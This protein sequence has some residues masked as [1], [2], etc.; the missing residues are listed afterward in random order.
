MIVN[1]G[2]PVV[3]EEYLQHCDPTAPIQRF[4]GTVGE[5]MIV[6]LQLLVRCPMHR[7]YSSGPPLNDD[8]DI[9]NVA[10]DVVQRLAEVR[11]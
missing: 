2:A 5:S 7:S 3:R 1:Y 10:L 8:F 6:T 4:T 9:F 11:K